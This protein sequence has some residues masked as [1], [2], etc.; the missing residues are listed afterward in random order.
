[1]LAGDLTPFHRVE[2]G[3]AEP[4]PASADPGEL[5]AF[6]GRFGR[7]EPKEEVR[8]RIDA[9]IERAIAPLSWPLRVV[10]RPAL[11]FTAQLPD[12]IAIELS[13]GLLGVTFS[14][15]VALRATPGG[16]SRLHHL[17][18]ATQGQVRHFWRAGQLWTEV[19]S[20]AGTITNVLEL[21]A[22]D[23]L[24]GHAQLES[25]YLPLPIRYAMRLRRQRSKPPA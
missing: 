25:Q 17:P 18:G 20:D 15:G 19:V 6:L 14:S 24:L 9:A 13:D 5:Q 23:E 4:L 3:V 10:A 21:S 22:E 12:W 16:P 1:M 11:R 7:D 2:R 8:A